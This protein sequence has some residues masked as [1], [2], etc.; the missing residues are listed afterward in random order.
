MKN[1]ITNFSRPYFQNTI[2]REINLLL[3]PLQQRRLDLRTRIITYW[4]T[5]RGDSL[6]VKIFSIGITGYGRLEMLPTFQD[7]Q[8]ITWGLEQEETRSDARSLIEI[9]GQIQCLT[10]LINK[11]WHAVLGGERIEDMH[12]DISNIIMDINTMRMNIS[13]MGMDINTMRTGILTETAKIDTDLSR[14][15][16]NFLQ[17]LEQDI[18]IEDPIAQDITTPFLATQK[19]ISDATNVLNATSKQLLRHSFV[20]SNPKE[21]ESLNLLQQT[22]KSTAKNTEEWRS[23][24]SKLEQDNMYTHLSI[25]VLESRLELDEVDQLLQTNQNTN[26]GGLT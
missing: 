3:T 5:H 21:S 7:E 16:K 14:W 15:H 26:T 20:V 25:S 17:T 18:S 12:T 8:I 13:K 19:E 24:F 6:A 22:I 2:I 4:N 10:Q 1:K 23:I 11:D 9:D